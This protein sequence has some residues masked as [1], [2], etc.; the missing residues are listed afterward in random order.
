RED[1]PALEKTEA[2]YRG[3]GFEHLGPRM[4]LLLDGDRGRPSFG[5]AEEKTTTREDSEEK[6]TT[7]AAGAA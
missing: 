1:F 7:R 5:D 2:F 3:S 4:R 6:T